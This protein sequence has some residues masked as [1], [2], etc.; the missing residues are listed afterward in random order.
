MY[1]NDGIQLIQ[2]QASRSKVLR[3]SKACLQV[4]RLATNG[5]QRE[6]EHRPV[7]PSR[8]PRSERE[9]APC[10]TLINPVN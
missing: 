2:P 9:F 4:K 7:F 10:K 5:R 8:P 3:L 6:K 1:L